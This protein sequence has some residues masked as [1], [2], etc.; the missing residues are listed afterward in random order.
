[1][2]DMDFLSGGGVLERGADSLPELPSVPAMLRSVAK[3]ERVEALLSDYLTLRLVEARSRWLRAHSIEGLATEGESLGVIAEL[4]EPG[5]A[6]A[7]L[8]ERIESVRER[9]RA[10]YDA[11]ISSGTIRAIADGS[12]Q[13]D[14][15]SPGRR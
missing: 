15:G 11:V 1:M 12:G 3:G 4:V 10:A 7:A 9:V 5:L 8:L 14:A 2:M 13:E 6:A